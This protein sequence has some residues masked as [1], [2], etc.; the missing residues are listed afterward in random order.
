MYLSVDEMRSR[1]S[2][3]YGPNAKAWKAKV[4]QM[5]DKQVIAVYN[6]FVARGRLSQVTAMLGSISNKELKALIVDMR[7]KDT[8]VFMD[9]L[10]EYKRLINIYASRMPKCSE[11]YKQ[12]SYL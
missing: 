10:E 11:D 6:S 5:H 8:Q 3:A 9:I 7:T 12:S 4:A 1:L 2:K